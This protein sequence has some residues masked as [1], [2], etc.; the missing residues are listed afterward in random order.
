MAPRPRDPSPPPAPPSGALADRLREPGWLLLPLRLFLGVTFCYAGLQKLANPTYLDVRAPASVAAQMQ[1]MR[2]TSP[3]G[4]LLGV[5]AHHA[6]T[7]GLLIAFGEL[8]VGLGVLLGLWTRA[9]AAGGMLLS[10]SFLLT[11]S[12]NTTPYYYGSD[13]VFLFAL[14]PLALGG[15]GGVLALDAAIAAVARRD[16]RLPVAAGGRT[17]RP[18]PAGLRRE[19]D[20]RVLVRGA[21]VAAVTAAGGLVLGGLTALAGRLA[22]GTDRSPSRIAAG[23]LSPATTPSG[24]AP[25]AGA[26]AA[27]VGRPIASS[28][29]IPVGHALQFN[30]PGSGGPAWLVHESPGNYR[31]FSAVCTHAGCTVDFDRQGKQFACPCHGATFD[32]GTGQV[33]GGPAPASLPAIPVRESGGEVRAI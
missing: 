3:I 29:R 12:W 16:L 9:A 8:A 25:A 10:L 33:T 17:G 18:V 31:A 19:L 23:G 28:G 21:A 14:S 5:T 26:S 6:T 2:H 11:V 13:I 7:V 4:P 1:A 20:R 15:S 24:P 27:P 22:G 32:A 30:D